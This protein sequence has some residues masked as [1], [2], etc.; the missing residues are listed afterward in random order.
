MEFLDQRMRLQKR[1]QAF[2]QL[3]R[4]EPVHDADLV[5]VGHE[6]VVEKPTDAIDGFVDRRA[7][8]VDLAQQSFARLE[9][10]ADA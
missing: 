3:S 8:D 7:D 9:I 5:Q 2:A 10:D 4:A 6:R 1:V